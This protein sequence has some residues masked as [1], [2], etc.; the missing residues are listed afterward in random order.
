[1][2]AHHTL[3]NKIIIMIILKWEMLRLTQSHIPINHLF[4][5]FKLFRLFNGKNSFCMNR[6]ILLPMKGMMRFWHSGLMLLTKTRQLQ[7][8]KFVWLNLP[9]FANCAHFNHHQSNAERNQ[10][11]KTVKE[12]KRWGKERK[13]ECDICVHLLDGFHFVPLQDNLLI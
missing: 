8:L 6:T 12:T 4:I 3:A 13:G 2:V 1:M 7:C 9:K 11:Q 5:F 10:V